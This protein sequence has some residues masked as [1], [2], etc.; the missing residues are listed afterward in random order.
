MGGLVA[1]VVNQVS[2]HVTGDIGGAG[3]SRFHYVTADGS[4]SG[5]AD[6]NTVGAAIHTFYNTGPS[7]YPADITFTIDAIVQQYEWTTGAIV[8]TVAMSSV[9][10]PVAGSSSA[11]YGAGLG[12]AI[13]WKTA[14]VRRR[15]LMRGRTFMVPLAANAFNTAGEVATSVVGA[16]T[17]AAQLLI[18]SLPDTGP[19]LVVWGRPT[20]HTTSDGV[21][22]EINSAVCSAVPAGLRSRRS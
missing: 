15:R 12:A 7:S 5:T 14:I 3:I 10:A 1:T 17:T 8:G 11:N 9:P 13:N 2:V 20:N 21:V 16:F 6:A 4:S 18:A 22:G 19:H